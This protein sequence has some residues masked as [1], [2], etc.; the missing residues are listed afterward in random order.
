MGTTAGLA[1]TVESGGKLCV[2]AGGELE[3]GAAGLVF[4]AGADYNAGAFDASTD[5]GGRILEFGPASPNFNLAT[6]AKTLPYPTL[7]EVRYCPVDSGGTLVSDCDA[8]NE[9]EAAI[10]C[11]DAKCDVGGAGTM[12]EYD[13]GAFVTAVNIND[14]L[15]WYDPG[16][17]G[18][19]AVRLLNW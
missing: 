12:G 11:P 3:I 17:L 18:Y 1:V 14:V 6:P 7:Y 13:W 9:Y 2:E 8:G 15:V 19:E 5:C 10:C 16:G 4:N